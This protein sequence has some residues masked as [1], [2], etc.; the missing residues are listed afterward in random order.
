MG[1]LN[2]SEKEKELHH[3]Q[4]SAHWVLQTDT[5][6]PTGKNVSALFFTNVYTRGSFCIVHFTYNFEEI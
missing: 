3:H 6:T 5:C 1:F 4:S 2:H